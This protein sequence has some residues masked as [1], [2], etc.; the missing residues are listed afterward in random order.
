MYI[1]DWGKCITHGVYYV[2]MKSWS[3]DQFVNSL[4]NL[5]FQAYAFISSS[6]L[7]SSSFCG[8]S[9]YSWKSVISVELRVLLEKLIGSA[10]SQEIPRILWNPEIHHRTHK[11]PQLVPIMSPLH[12]VPTTHSHFLKIRFNIILPSTSGS[13]QWSLSLRFPHQ[14]PLQ[15]SPLPFPIRA[16]C[17]TH[18]LLL[19]FTTR[20]LLCK[21]YR[22]LAPPYVIFSILMLPRPS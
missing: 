12:P 17:P 11:C 19:D 3:K 22:S 2:F 5:T 7:F 18:L 20:T 6:N 13:L 15:T 4:E 8:V 9:S 10:A 1:V 21:E 16:T 14:N